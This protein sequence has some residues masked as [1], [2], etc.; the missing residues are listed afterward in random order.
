MGGSSSKSSITK[1]TDI[2]FNAVNKNI[3]SCVGAASQNQ[4]IKIQNVH[5]DID[6]SGT[7]QKQGVT[8]NMKCAFSNEMQ[9]QIQNQIASDIS[10]YVQSKGGDITALAASSSKSDTTIK[11]ILK[12]SIHNE[13]LSEQVASAIQSQTVSIADVG[14]SVIASGLTQEQGAKVVSEAI[15]DTAQYTGALMKVAA[16]VD[17]QA[18]AENKGIFNSMFD[19][20]GS[21][22]NSWTMI[23][24]VFI[25]VFILIGFVAFIMFGSFFTGGSSS[26]P[27]AA[28]KMPRVR[29]PQV[30][31]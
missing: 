24:V 23:A 15:V 3:Q 20:L 8:I 6:L 29:A 10:N 28:A 9:N 1:I 26:A 7:K 11:N 16:Y 31:R 5:G 30:V 17:A 12:T 21:L 18:K 22:F 13:T 4:L 2:A 27:A 25:A 14:G 19:M